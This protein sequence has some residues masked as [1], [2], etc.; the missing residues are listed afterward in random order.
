MSWPLASSTSRSTEGRTRG[1]RG[2]QGSNTPIAGLWGLEVRDLQEQGANG[3]HQRATAEPTWASRGEGSR[4]P[5][6]CRA[7]IPPRKPPTCQRELCGRRRCL[8]LADPR[9]A[10]C[11]TAGQPQLGQRTE[12]GAAER[13]SRR[14][15][16]SGERCGPRAVMLRANTC[17]RDQLSRRV[18][19]QEATRS[20]HTG[21][22]AARCSP[23]GL[24]GCCP[25]TCC[26]S[27]LG[28]LAPTHNPEET[29]Q[30]PGPVGTFQ[31]WLWLWGTV[32]Q[33][34]KVTRWSGPCARPAGGRCDLAQPGWGLPRLG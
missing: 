11:R 28:S 2:Q 15:D 24:P 26:P 4:V 27:S 25:A 30:D 31:K 1:T 13:R 14:R 22:G 10:L 12:G 5:Q 17:S 21:L 33:E 9:L 20:P 3:L 29:K 34:S 18:W 32:H 6:G 7:E 19:G 23:K 8:W 16:R